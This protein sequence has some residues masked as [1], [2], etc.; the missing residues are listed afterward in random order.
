MSV[1]T[2]AHEPRRQQLSHVLNVSQAKHATV[3]TIPTELLQ[4]IKRMSLHAEAYMTLN[5]SYATDR[6]R[7][8]E[9]EYDAS[10][11]VD[12]GQNMI[13]RLPVASRREIVAFP[14][15]TALQTLN[16]EFNAVFRSKV[17]EHLGSRAVDSAEE[18]GVFDRQVF[19]THG[20]SANWLTDLHYDAYIA[21]ADLD[22]QQL[23]G[24]T[25]TSDHTDGR[26]FRGPHFLEMPFVSALSVLISRLARVPVQRVNW[27]VYDRTGAELNKPALADRAPDDSGEHFNCIY[28]FYVMVESRIP[29]HML[30]ADPS[31]PPARLPG[32]T[33]REELAARQAA[34]NAQQQA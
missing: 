22:A 15:N 1:R 17:Q 23:G 24:S 33:W 34:N 5:V 19:S 3:S 14:R 25:L 32:A 7:E 26:D 30:Y 21:D 4:S 8:D 13:E 27:K 18:E 9:Y 28:H 11:G 20:T 31:D 16:D 12:G 2:T 29:P 10:G 6:D